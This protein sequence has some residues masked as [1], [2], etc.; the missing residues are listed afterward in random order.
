[1]NNNHPVSTL[2]HGAQH[3]AGKKLFLQIGMSHAY[4]WLQ[5]PTTSKQISEQLS[6]VFR[7]AQT[8][9]NGQLTMHKCYFGATELNFLRRTITPKAL[10]LT[11]QAFNVP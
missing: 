6:S 10:N 1:M 7:N 9:R 4:H 8:Y 3:M 5:M 11:N 2:T